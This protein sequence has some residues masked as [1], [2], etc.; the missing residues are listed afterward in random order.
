MQKIFETPVQRQSGAVNL[1]LVI[2]IVAVLAI[3][4]IAAYFFFARP[5]SELDTTLSA[6]PT[7]AE[8]R[9]DSARETIAKLKQEDTTTD[10]ET[11]YLQAT[12]HRAAGRHG[13]AQLL[14][15]FAA[16][17]GHAAAAFD[18]ATMYDPTYFSSESSVTGKADPFQAYKWYKQ[19]RESGYVQ[20]GARIA[21]LKIWATNAA[22][23]G[24]ADAERLMI[25]MG[26]N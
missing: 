2:S 6:P 7:T 20:A 4:V 16:R 22:L 1:P 12:E 9:G 10:L 19:A 21:E 5:S 24:D 26:A 3:I 13:D 8:E 14:Y 17:G 23:D 15:F 18:L 25:S 11:A